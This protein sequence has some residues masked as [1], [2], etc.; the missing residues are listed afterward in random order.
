LESLVNAFDKGVTHQVE[1]EIHSSQVDLVFVFWAT[2]SDNEVE[3]KLASLK[4]ETVLSQV[5]IFNAC[6]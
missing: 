4:P 6:S 3:E 2:T 5:E 1:S